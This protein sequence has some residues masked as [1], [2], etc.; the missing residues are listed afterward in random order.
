MESHIK[1]IG[2]INIIFGALGLLAAAIV[3]IAVAGGGILSRDPEAIT[4]TFIVAM[5]ISGILSILAIPELIAGWG[6]LK[7]KSWSRLLGIILA[8][9][10]LLKFPLGTAFGIYA[11][12]VLMNEETEKIFK[13]HQPGG[14][15]VEQGQ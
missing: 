10:D 2:L 14:I 1:I 6:L 4:I 13:K 5:A 11:L 15:V 12:W 3:F 9:L 7:L 8:I